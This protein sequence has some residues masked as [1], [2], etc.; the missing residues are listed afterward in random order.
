MTTLHFT[1]VVRVAGLPNQMPS[2]Y[3]RLGLYDVSDIRPKLRLLGRSH[4]SILPR[5]ANIMQI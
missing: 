5:Q 3:S 1:I 2:M 4:N